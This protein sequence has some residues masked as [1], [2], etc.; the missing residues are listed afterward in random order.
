[1]PRHAMPSSDR[2]ARIEEQAER[3]QPD[4]DADGAIVARAEHLLQQAGRDDE[5]RRER[6][7]IAERDVRSPERPVRRIVGAH[8]ARS[9][10]QPPAAASTSGTAIANPASFTASCTTLT[11]ADVS[12]PPAMK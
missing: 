12:S 2:N 8:V 9:P 1:M 10:L 3:V 7:E 4:A 11:R 5:R 6:E